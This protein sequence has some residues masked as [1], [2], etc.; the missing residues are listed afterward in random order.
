MVEDRSLLQAHGCS[1]AGVILL[2]SHMT[3]IVVWADA[4]ATLILNRCCD[5]LPLIRRHVL[6]LLHH[7]IIETYLSFVIESSHLL[8]IVYDRSDTS[9]I[10]FLDRLI[11]VFNNANMTLFIHKRLSALESFLEIT[12]S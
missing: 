2:K 12:I 5:C 11:C 7:V 10:H 6:A 4:T 8:I 1:I 3:A 9:C